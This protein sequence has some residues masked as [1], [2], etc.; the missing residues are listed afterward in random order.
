[1]KWK[2]IFAWEI[3]SE[4]PSSVWDNFVITVHFDDLPLSRN[5]LTPSLKI[6]TVQPCICKV[7]IYL[8]IIHYQSLFSYHYHIVIFFVRERFAVEVFI[9]SKSSLQFIGKLAHFLIKYF[10][11][12]VKFRKLHF[13]ENHI[14]GLFHVSSNP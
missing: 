14:Y 1:M 5:Y 13:C 10:L 8:K 9:Y 4:S 3:D 11:L 6:R 7:R 2:S 12:I